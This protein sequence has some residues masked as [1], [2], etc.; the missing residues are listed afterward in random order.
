MNF[1]NRVLF[2][3]AKDGFF[4]WAWGH[5]KVN[6]VGVL[7]ENNMEGTVSIERQPIIIATLKSYWTEEM[8]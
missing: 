3:G 1:A 6:K 8:C 5:D 7:L 2:F 4:H